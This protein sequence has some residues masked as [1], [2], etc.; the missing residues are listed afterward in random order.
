MP[1]A[2]MELNEKA[3]RRYR[4]ELS[5]ISSLRIPGRREMNGSY[6]TATSKQEDS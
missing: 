3:I 4:R 5:N 6:P 2:I 1:T